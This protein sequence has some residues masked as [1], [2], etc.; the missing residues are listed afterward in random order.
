MQVDSEPLQVYVVCALVQNFVFGF[1][2]WQAD[3]AQTTS[4]FPKTS[5]LAMA[6][7]ANAGVDRN[8]C[9]ALLICVSFFQQ[10]VNRNS[11]GSYNALAAIG[12]KLQ[13]DFQIAVERCLATRCDEHLQPML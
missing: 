9:F 2:T 10:T 6:H 4:W 8:L 5:M 7:A 13:L 12:E 1:G 3:V 11:E